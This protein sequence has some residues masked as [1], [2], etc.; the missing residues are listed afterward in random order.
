MKYT[1][2]KVKKVIYDVIYETSK[3]LE[4]DDSADLINQISNKLQFELPD[5]FLYLRKFS[6]EDSKLALVSGF[7]GFWSEQLNEEELEKFKK[8]VENANKQLK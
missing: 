1:Q 4:L 6:N 5:C 3:G 2:Q 7:V 8:L